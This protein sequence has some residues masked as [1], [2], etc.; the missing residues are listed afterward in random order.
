M[1]CRGYK[2]GGGRA[3]PPTRPAR[4]GPKT[5]RHDDKTP[6]ADKPTGAGASARTRGPRVGVGVQPR[7]PRARGSSAQAE[8][9]VVGDVAEVGILAA[10]PG[11][12]ERLGHLAVA[13]R[14]ISIRDLLSYKSGALIS[15][16]HPIYIAP[17]L[18]TRLNKLYNTP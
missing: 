13:G 6:G 14:V 15:L 9:E 16:V 8:A 2:K 17:K 18:H 4:P 5:S 11:V 3:Q 12:E 7:G 10:V 1:G